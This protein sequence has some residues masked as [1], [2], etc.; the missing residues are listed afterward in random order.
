MISFQEDDTGSSVSDKTVFSPLDGTGL[1]VS[2]TVRL[3]GGSTSPNAGRV[4]VLHDGVW[5][6]VCDDSWDDVDASVVCN[7]LGYP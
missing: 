6:T 7:S 2:G 1:T 5:G 4:E 3:V